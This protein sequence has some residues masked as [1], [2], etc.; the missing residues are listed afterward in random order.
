MHP[1]NALST[2]LSMDLSRKVMAVPPAPFNNNLMI[3]YTP[4]QIFYLELLLCLHCHLLLLFHISCVSGD[5]LQQ[6]ITLLRGCLHHHLGLR[7][8][9][10]LPQQTSSFHGLRPT[11]MTEGTCGNWLHAQA[12]SQPS[13]YLDQLLQAAIKAR[14]HVAERS[15]VVLQCVPAAKMWLWLGCAGSGHDRG[16]D[17]TM[18]HSNAVASGR[19]H[20]FTGRQVAQHL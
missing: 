13:A 20:S 19:L 18:Q 7:Q 15:P 2:S 3:H 1:C 4:Q 17:A 9:Q 6:P 5:D 16:I 11:A 10:L 12:P 14:C 8:L